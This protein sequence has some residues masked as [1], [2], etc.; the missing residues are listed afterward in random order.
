MMNQIRN[1]SGAEPMD[2][3]TIKQRVLLVLNLYDKIN[4]EKLT[5][6]SHFY[7][8]LGLD[9]LDHVEVLISFFVCF[10]SRNQNNRRKTK[11]FPLNL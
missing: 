10:I 4:P 9:S 11:H 6:D 5:V 7:K 8:H 3:E 2:L 1:Y